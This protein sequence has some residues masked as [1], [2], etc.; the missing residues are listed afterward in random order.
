MEVIWGDWITQGHPKCHVR[1]TRLPI[2]L[3][4]KLCVCLIPFSTDSELFVK[5]R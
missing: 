1:C 2:Y 5:S 4:Y 3:S